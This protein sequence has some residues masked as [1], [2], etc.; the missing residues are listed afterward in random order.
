MEKMKLTVAHFYPKQLNLHGTY[1]NVLTLK[2]RCQWRGIEL[3]TSEINLNG[4]LEKHD[5]YFIGTGQEKQQA[6]VAADLLRHKDFLTQER[7]ENAVF[8]GVDS[9]YQLLGNYFETQTYGKLKGLGLLDLYT[10]P[11]KERFVGNVIAQCDFLT[12]NTLVGFENHSGMAY[13]E[14]ETRPLA[15]II[16]GNGNNGTDKTEGARFKNVFGTYLHGPLLPKNPNFADYLLTLALTQKYG[17]DVKLAPLEDTLETMT[18]D[19]LK[20]YKR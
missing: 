15:K 17:K 12:P 4:A 10:K 5:I 6:D 1:G 14:G 8:L 7:D 20:E 13:L 2:K 19:F 3:S 11:G 9:G 16:S 18:H